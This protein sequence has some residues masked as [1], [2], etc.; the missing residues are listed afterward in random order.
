MIAMNVSKISKPTWV[1]ALAIIGIV[2]L[3]GMFLLSPASEPMS[4]YLK[5]GEFFEYQLQ[6]GEPKGEP[7]LPKDEP[8]FPELPSQ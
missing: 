2:A 4:L 1:I 8:S 3:S 7:S 6:K 5:F